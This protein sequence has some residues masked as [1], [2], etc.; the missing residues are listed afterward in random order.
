M[1]G[2][3]A[4]EY[5][6]CECIVSV[7]CSVSA[8]V[9]CLDA[10]C[11][12]FRLAGVSAPESMSSRAELDAVSLLCLLRFASLSGSEYS[13]KECISSLGRFLERLPPEPIFRSRPLGRIG[14]DSC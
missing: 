14:L 2:H 3:R 5:E 4:A 6:A 10:D 9:D 1:E 13:D 7:S 8:V 12:R 11:L